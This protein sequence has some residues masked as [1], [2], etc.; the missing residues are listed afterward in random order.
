MRTEIEDNYIHFYPDDDEDYFRLGC[1][2]SNGSFEKSIIR[3]NGNLSELKIN[4]NELLKCLMYNY[5][6]EK[7]E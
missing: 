1:I 6:V 2:W 7:H 5:K 4:I 3:G